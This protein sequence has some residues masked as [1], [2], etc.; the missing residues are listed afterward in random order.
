MLPLSK[1]LLATMALFSIVGH[2]NSF[3]N[4]VMYLRSSSKH[5]IQMMLRSLLISLEMVQD[6]SMAAVAKDITT[7]TRTVKGAG[8]M[9]AIIP[10]LCIYPFLQKYFAKGVMIGSIKE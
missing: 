10:I 6:E 3:L 9:I 8:V 1:P 7:S 4:A 2:W 5:P